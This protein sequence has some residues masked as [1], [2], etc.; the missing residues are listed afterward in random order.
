MIG[1]N[2]KSPLGGTLAC[3]VIAANVGCG[4]ITPVNLTPPQSAIDRDGTYL[5]TVTG[6]GSQGD[7]G[8][9][10]TLVIAGGLFT[11]LGVT[12]MTPQAITVTGANY[13]WVSAAAKVLSAQ[14]PFP[15]TTNVTLNVDLQNDGTLTGTMTFAA[16]GQTSNPLSV[17]LTKQ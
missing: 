7:L 10:P 6:G 1:R 15:V 11:K 14:I 12:D 5:I 3:F 13:V 4:T 16:L 9:D 17:T 8:A 2:W